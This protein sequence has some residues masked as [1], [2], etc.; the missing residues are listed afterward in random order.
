MLIA[1]G[2][3]YADAYESR[4]AVPQEDL[5]LWLVTLD[6]LIKMKRESDRPIDRQDIDRLT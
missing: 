5:E 6:E 1:A 3:T 2:G 4:Y